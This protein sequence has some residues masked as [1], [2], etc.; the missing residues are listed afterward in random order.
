MAG[1]AAMPPPISGGPGAAPPA[2]ET[3][4][5]SPATNPTAT[6]TKEKES[7]SMPMA[8]QGNNHSSESLEPGKAT[9]PRP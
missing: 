8:G 4:K 3:A 9:T 6:L 2:T 1:T 7:N 5:D